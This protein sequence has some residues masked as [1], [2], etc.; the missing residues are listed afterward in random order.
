MDGTVALIFNEY[1][2]RKSRIYSIKHRICCFQVVQVL[3]IS[4]GSTLITQKTSA[5]TSLRRRRLV[6]TIVIKV[7][8]FHGIVL[9]ICKILNDK[10]E[11]PGLTIM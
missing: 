3:S 5:Q 11:Q 6:G 10:A 7:C 4:E 9:Q 8:C 1:T 2:I